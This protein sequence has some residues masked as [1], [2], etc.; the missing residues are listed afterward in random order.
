METVRD[1][2][3][4]RRIDRS[5][6]RDGQ[7]DHAIERPC[8]RAGMPVR[9]SHTLRHAYGT[10]TALFGVSPWRLQAWLGHKRCDETMLCVHVAESHRR[11]I[12]RRQSWQP[13][14]SRVCPQILSRDLHHRQSCRPGRLTPRPNLRHLLV[15]SPSG[16]AQW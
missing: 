13:S 14:Y 16:V 3:V 4:G 9:Y 7:S 11:D 6:M 5:A 12:P 10:H 2:F 15:P 8:R 1:G